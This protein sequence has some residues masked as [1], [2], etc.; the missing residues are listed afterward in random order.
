MGSNGGLTKGKSHA[1]GGINMTVKS[2]G[3]QIEVEGGEG[4]INKYVMSDDDKYDFE[5]KEMTAC[6]IAS[7][8]NQQNGNGVKFSCEE[9]ENTD[10][11]PLDKEE[12]FAKG[13]G[14][15]TMPN[16]EVILKYVNFED[17]WRINLKRLKD[18][19]N[20]NKG[21]NKYVIIRQDSRKEQELWEFETL[22]EANAKFNEL[23]ELGKTY[24]KIEKQ[25]AK[26][27]GIA[28]TIKTQTN[29]RH[30][31]T[32]AV[33]EI[34]EDLLFS[35]G[36]NIEMIE[37][38]NCGWDWKV[39]D[40]GD[41]L[42]ICHKCNTDN[43]FS[44][45]GN[46]FGTP[47]SE[48]TKI[49]QKYIRE[50]SQLLG[51]TDTMPTKVTTLDYAKSIR[52]ADEYEAMKDA[53]TDRKVQEA[54]E[55]LA[56]ETEMQYN[57]V[58]DKGYKL[59]LWDG[60]G[61]PYANSAELLK[62][63]SDN[64]HMYVFA[65][66]GGFGEE[67]ITDLQRDQNAMLR[68]T[69]YKD[70]KGKPLLVNDLF[71]FVHDFFGHSE[72]GNSFGA[73]GEEN[74]WMA[75]SRMFSPQARRA[76]TTETRGQ[77]SWVNFGK[78]IRRSDNSIPK[79]GDSDYTPLGKRPFADQKMNLI[80]DDYTFAKGGEVPL[81]TGSLEE[82]RKKFSELKLKFK[83]DGRGYYSSSI[84]VD[85]NN[86]KWL[87]EGSEKHWTYTVE[88]NGNNIHDDGGVS[89]KKDWISSAN[90]D[91]WQ[92]L[93][94]ECPHEEYANG[95]LVEWYDSKEKDMNRGNNE[96][97]IHAW[98]CVFGGDRPS[99]SQVKKD[100]LKF[101]M[102]E[103]MT[104]QELHDQCEEIYARGGVLGDGEYYVYVVSI[105]NPNTTGNFPRETETIFVSAKSKFRAIWGLKVPKGFVV[106]RVV[107]ELDF[108]G[109]PV[110]SKKSDQI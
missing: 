8:L 53:P 68:K 31:E 26:G 87:I 75:H 27:G 110:I 96:S 93:N 41:D 37:C 17:G 48:T 44:K 88:K 13:G 90:N 7:D 67:P 63:I 71:R 1:K 58:I 85:G 94:G 51:L 15:H 109:D 5:G 29:P 89:L 4:I 54:Y 61:E 36:G 47:N 46:I 57:A 34:L 104:M 84:N 42:Y 45:G 19:I 64:K 95:G 77:N 52:L 103:G 59:E 56:H 100:L 106:S 76:M 78:H 40:G 28:K 91:Y 18:Y 73:I 107:K 66:E 80:G 92:I 6:E 74:A 12:G 86:W 43:E 72:L 81:L 108:K 82:R 9:T 22:N 38:Q 101:L 83:K 97:Y 39:S 32:D 30:L 24:S 99:I 2:T 33:E 79:K 69:G 98:D 65:T 11:T 21:N 3:Q 23:V 62:D 55:V 14:V 35:K 16:G 60:K 10:L 25:F 105:Y 20:Q 70:V 102:E 49:A 50:N